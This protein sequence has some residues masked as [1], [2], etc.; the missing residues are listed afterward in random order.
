MQIKKL[1]STNIMASQLGLGCMG[2]SEFYGPRN[3]AEFLQTLRRAIE[4]GVTFWDTADAYGPHLNEVLVG[5]ALKGKRDKIT[6]ATKFGI[7]RDPNNTALRS[8]N[9]RPEY[10]KQACEN[11]LKRLGVDRLDLYY[12]HRVDP[13]T[14]VED[15]VGAMAELVAEG[16]IRGIGLSEVSAATLERMHKTVHPITAVESEYSLWTRDPE[17][18]VLQTCDRLHIA[19]VAYSPLGRGFLTDQIKSP[20]DFAADDYRRF[21]PRFQGENFSKNLTLVKK[22]E[23]LATGKKCTPSQLALAWVLAQGEF[24]FPIP[25]TKRIKYLEE[26]VG[27]LNI[28]L[29]KEERSSIDALFPKDAASGMRYPENMMGSIGK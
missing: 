21:S 10:V 14:P 11:S 23:A 2:M 4:L 7:A 17:G 8:L 3:D 29:S 28:S 25:G 19:F 15:T 5:K 16:K 24:I 18:G 20:D 9:G 27:A 12:L 26:N 22:V 1:G 6:L 13:E